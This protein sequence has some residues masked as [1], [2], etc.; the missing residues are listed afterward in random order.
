MLKTDR[1]LKHNVGG[2]GGRYV[3]VKFTHANIFYRIINEATITVRRK[4]T[5]NYNINY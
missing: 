5:H 4:T 1:A 2:G 3:G